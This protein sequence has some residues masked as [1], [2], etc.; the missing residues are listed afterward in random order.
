MYDKHGFPIL[1]RARKPRVRHLHRGNGNLFT[2]IQKERARQLARKAVKRGQII[3]L[4]YCQKC[5]REE[6]EV[7]ITMHHYDY[8]YPLRVRF[9]CVD[10][11]N[12]IDREGG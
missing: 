10:C 8:N 9:L 6:P 3:K 4:D 12:F 11:H 1:S 7:E 5:L 2:E